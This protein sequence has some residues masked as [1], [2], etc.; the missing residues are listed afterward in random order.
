MLIGVDYHP[1]FQQ[2]AFFDE[3]TGECGER[4]LNHSDGEAER[5]YRDLQKRGI[6]VRVGMEATGY[7]RWFERLLAELGIEIW[8]GDPAEI[9]AKRVKKRKTD[10]NDALLLLRLM[11][12]DNFPRIWVP[13]PEN[14]DLRQLLWHRHR[15][16][17]MRTRIMNQLQ[18]LAMNEGY[19][20]KK[21]L[22][23]EQGRSQLEK[24]ALA[25][26]ASRRR[27]EL[28]ELLDRMNPRIEDLTA[29]VEQEASKRPEVLRLMTHPGVGALT[30]L[31]YVLIIGTPTRFQRGKQIGT[32]V[33]MIPSEDS[34][35]GK[36]RLGHISK[37]GN[38]LLRFLLVEAAQA[39]ARIHPDWRR[40]Y[41][42]LAMRRH[43]S[44]AKVAMGRRLAIRLYW[45]WRN[46]C[47]Y[48]P[49]LEF[50]SYAGQLGTGHGAQ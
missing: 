20:W 3:V 17:Q 31:A 15:L 42:H 50:G 35:A 28:L 9:K 10:R 8:M 29:A 30:A 7:S 34:S 40:R 43:K 37:Q 32:Y 39:A 41:I 44:I 18:A 11:R 16:V 6:R 36:Q 23:S 4:Q 14:R 33:G 49:S 1:S 27:Q 5:F 24:L 12:E 26:W 22:F 19:R 48:S 47:E 38:S 21:K 45:M 25:P 13:S 46:G 2:I